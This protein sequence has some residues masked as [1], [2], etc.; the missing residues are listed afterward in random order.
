MPISLFRISNGKT[1]KTQNSTLLLLPV[2]DN[3]AS[4]SYWS[5]GIILIVKEKLTL[6]L[7]ILSMLMIVVIHL[8]PTQMNLKLNFGALKRGRFRS[9]AS[10]SYTC[11]KCCWRTSTEKNTCGIAR[12]PCGS[13]AFLFCERVVD[14]WNGLSSHHTDFSSL[15]RFR[16]C[17][18]TINFSVYLEF[19]WLQILFLIL[20]SVW[21]IVFV[22]F[23]FLGSCQCLV[24]AVLLY[25]TMY[26]LLHF[27]NCFIEQMN[28]W[29]N[30]NTLTGVWVLCFV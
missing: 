21:C 29:M 19:V 25:C 30:C 2:P 1:R 6:I 28:E 4:Q 17:I 26:I 22:Y 15:P 9:L 3:S 27:F 20:I 23:K 7:V 24:L 16:R 14:I 5:S 11:S 13:T 12:F 10:L 18:N 8:L